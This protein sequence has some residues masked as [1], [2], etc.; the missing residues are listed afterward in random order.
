MHCEKIIVCGSYGTAL[1]EGVTAAL[2]RATISINH[3]LVDS[4]LRGFESVL[5]QL[6]TGDNSPPDKIK[7]QLLPTRT[8]I[9]RTTPH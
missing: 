4:S 1:R 5:G 8:T 2:K 3:G 7:A 9:P 6:P